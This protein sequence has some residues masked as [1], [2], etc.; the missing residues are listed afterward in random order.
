MSNMIFQIP[1]VAKKRDAAAVAALCHRR[2][3]RR[4]ATIA[5]ARR[6]NGHGAK[7]HTYNSFYCLDAHNTAVSFIVQHKTRR[8]PTFDAIA[9]LGS[10]CTEG[11]SGRRAVEGGGVIGVGLKPY[12]ISNAY[13]RSKGKKTA[14]LYN[15]VRLH[16]VVAE[17]QTR[18]YK[19]GPLPTWDTGRGERVL[20][21]PKPCIESMYEN[22]GMHHVFP[23]GENFFSGELEPPLRAPSYEP[24]TYNATQRAVPALGCRRRTRCRC[25]SPRRHLY[26]SLS[27]PAK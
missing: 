6:N 18:R 7:Q 3:K 12:E 14:G 26:S 9:L 19:P 21:G 23:K 16:S 20:R 4:D 11:G 24:A 10:F 25:S 13:L 22:N 8:A 15:L 1:R 5:I 17:L 27:P 2:N